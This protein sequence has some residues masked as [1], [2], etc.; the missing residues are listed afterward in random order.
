M[1]GVEHGN[2]TKQSSRTITIFSSL[3]YKKTDGAEQSGDGNEFRL[4]EEIHC[5][6]NGPVLAALLPQAKQI[7]H[8]YL[9]QQQIR[10]VNPQTLQEKSV[11]R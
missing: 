6:Q 3:S 9:V 5:L 4:S 2:R 11:M 8:Q 7:Q 10:I 1:Y